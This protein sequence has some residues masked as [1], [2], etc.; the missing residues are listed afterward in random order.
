MKRHQKHENKKQAFTLVELIIVISIIAI[1]ATI[2]FIS[3]KNYSWNARDWNRIT[4]IKNIQTWLDLYMMKTGKYPKP[5]W[6]IQIWTLWWWDFAYK[7]EIG[8]SISRQIWLN[9]APKRSRNKK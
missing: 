3:F 9:K 7:W 4:S 2:A 1:L 5:E 6:N 8:E